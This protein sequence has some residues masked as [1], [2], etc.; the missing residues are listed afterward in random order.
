MI[1]SPGRRYIFVHIPKTGGTSLAAALETRA[2]A[3][4]ILIGDTPKARRRRRRLDALPARGR[5]CK[6]SGLADI[7]GVLAPGEIAGMFV[8]TLVRNPWDRMVS[9]YAWAREQSFDHP[10][11]RAAKRLGFSGF[12]ADPGVGETLRRSPARSYVTD[13]A[14]TERCAA[15]VRLEY[16]ETDRGQVWD[17]LGFRLDVPRLNAS[18]R[19]RDYRSYYDAPTR[20]RVAEVHAENIARFDYA[21]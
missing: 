13:A 10:A 20:R 16:L 21:W 11:I 14:G 4:D 8:F 19:K 17:H 12:V 18:G 1:V 6:H 15:F 2:M 9:Y 5:L 7:D 3:D